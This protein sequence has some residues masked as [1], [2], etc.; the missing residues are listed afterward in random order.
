MANLKA[1]YCGLIILLAFFGM[2][3][4]LPVLKTEQVSSNE[5]L[6]KAAAYIAGRYDN[7]IGLVSDPKTTEA[8]SQIILPVTELSGSTMT[9]SGHPKR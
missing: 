4:P 5:D 7:R 8:T 2:I 9:T 3:T 1:G 6:L